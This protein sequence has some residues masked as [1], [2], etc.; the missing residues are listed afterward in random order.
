MVA[1]TKGT[2]MRVSWEESD[3]IPGRQV[4]KQTI[5]ERLLIGFL[6]AEHG[7]ARFVMVSLS[8][9]MTQPAM[10]RRELAIWLTEGGWMPATLL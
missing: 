5:R 7:D 8:D 10:K 1:G 4:G 2:T 3:V 9:G 6:A